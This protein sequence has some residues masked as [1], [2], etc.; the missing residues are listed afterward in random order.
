M[1]SD[2]ILPKTTPLPGSVHIKYVRCGKPSCRCANGALHGPYRRRIWR[3]DGRTRYGYVPLSQA[4]RTRW[5][6]IA[7]R[8]Q[9]P[10]KRSLL[11]ELRELRRL[12]GLVEGVGDDA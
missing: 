8:A 4:E 12:A 7:W 2:Q 10:S 9:H 11:R 3:E 1:I 6:T 5:A